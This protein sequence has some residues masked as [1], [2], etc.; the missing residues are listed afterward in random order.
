MQLS[1]QNF[2]KIRNSYK[3][4]IK[5]IFFLLINKKRIKV[6]L[7][8]G[9][10]YIW[11]NL[12]V[13]NYIVAYNLTYKNDAKV[14]FFPE[15]DKIEFN[16]LG[17]RFTFFGFLENGWIYHELINFEY[18]EL[19][20]KNKI[21]LDIGANSGATSVFFILNDAKYVFAIEPMPKT[22]SILNENIEI[23]KLTGFISP[24]N[25]GIGKPS[26]VNLNMDIS[27]LG[28]DINSAVTELG[29][30]VEIKSL[31]FII[32]KYNID[33]CILKMDCEGCEYDALLSLDRNTMEHFSEIML[34]YHYG[35]LNLKKFLEENGYNVSCTD[36][37]ISYNHISK[38]IMKVGFLHAWKI[39]I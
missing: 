33:K 16:Y 34:E 26:K 37:V 6:V 21:V 32:E 20:F 23:N 28:A 39:D 38:T 7:K 30:T 29:K 18:N 31:S 8:N 5:V 9:N 14:E 1:F 22:Y 24:L 12:Q 36:P 2:K 4:Y 25:Y 35:C 11:N 13:R 10:I 27:G 17:K 19:N 15:M 3:N